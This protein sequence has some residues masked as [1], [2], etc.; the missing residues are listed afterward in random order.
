[1]MYAWRQVFLKLY[2]NEVHGRNVSLLFCIKNERAN[3]SQWRSLLS[4]EMIKLRETMNVFE[5]LPMNRAIPCSHTIYVSG[6]FATKF[7][8][9]SSILSVSKDA[10]FIIFVMYLLDKS[11]YSRV[12]H[13]RLASIENNHHFT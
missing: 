6:C 3:G 5:A 2:H 7:S 8:Y 11:S 9:F 1:M 13:Y 10:I 4:H 12:M